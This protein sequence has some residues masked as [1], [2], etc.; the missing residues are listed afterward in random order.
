MPI[1][2]FVIAGGMLRRIPVGRL[3]R[4]RCAVL[5]T[6][7]DA[8]GSQRADG[9]IR[10]SHWALMDLARRCSGVGPLQPLARVASP[11]RLMR[12]ARYG[13][14]ARAR[15]A[16]AAPLSAGVRRETGHY[17]NSE[18]ANGHCARV[19]RTSAADGWTRAPRLGAKNNALNHC[20]ASAILAISPYD[21]K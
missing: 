15:A 1:K 9:K 4:C 11:C 16:A 7:P 13:T 14:T 19:V 8:R 17:R 18:A 3:I 5:F 2:I 21:S 6:T 20:T 12:T 10:Q